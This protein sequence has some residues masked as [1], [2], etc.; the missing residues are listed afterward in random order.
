MTNKMQENQTKEMQ[1][2]S[3]TKTNMELLRLGLSVHVFFRL[4]AAYAAGYVGYLLL[5]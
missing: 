5:E 3:S 1:M 4:H 2:E